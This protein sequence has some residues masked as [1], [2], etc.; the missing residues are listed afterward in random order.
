MGTVSVNN[1]WVEQNK[2]SER[3][4][5][6]HTRLMIQNIMNK[7]LGTVSVN[8]WWVEQNKTSEHNKMRHT[9]LM[10]QNIMNK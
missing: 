2:T 8:N 7:L 1:W 10:I 4:K 9:R 5:M 3:N 6:R